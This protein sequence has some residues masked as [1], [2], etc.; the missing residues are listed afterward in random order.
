MLTTPQPPLEEP[1]L[2]HDARAVIPYDYDHLD[3]LMR[4][5]LNLCKGNF[6]KE[7]KKGFSYKNCLVTLFLFLFYPGIVA[8]VYFCIMSPHM[9]EKEDRQLKKMKFLDPEN[10]C[11][12][13]ISYYA[14]CNLDDDEA[15][16]WQ[17]AGLSSEECKNLI[18]HHKETLN[19]HQGN[20]IGYFAIIVC[21]I[22][23]FLFALFHGRVDPAEVPRIISYPLAQKKAMKIKANIKEILRYFS[24]V[25]LKIS[26]NTLKEMLWSFLNLSHYDENY[27]DLTS[28]KYVRRIRTR[29]HFTVA[30]QHQFIT[31]VSLYALYN[32]LK[33][34][35]CYDP[36]ELRYICSLGGRHRFNFTQTVLDRIKVFIEDENYETII[37][38]V[39]NNFD[40]ILEMVLPVF[41]VLSSIKNSAVLLKHQEKYIVSSQGHS[42]S[43]ANS[44]LIAYMS[45]IKSPAH[46]LIHSFLVGDCRVPPHPGLS[47]SLQ[48][49]IPTLATS[50]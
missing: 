13:D 11:S 49:N 48:G 1:L 15:V 31:I 35:A 25:P 37:D 27:D 40:T 20:T 10:S 3:R 23:P 28:V 16:T 36:V 32:R 22:T 34:A 38:P 7:L 33:N 29:S 4:N 24:V 6:T 45:S 50:S 46:H 5:T 12:Y 41:E 39:R 17:E 19:N 9:K 44:Q 21:F 8:L 47:V 18:C 42:N 26:L 2:S 43:N 14:L 30:E